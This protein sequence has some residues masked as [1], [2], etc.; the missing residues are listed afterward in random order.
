MVAMVQDG[1]EIRFARSGSDLAV[2]FVELHEL[3]ERPATPGALN[4]VLVQLLP[5]GSTR[6][7]RFLDLWVRAEVSTCADLLFLYQLQPGEATELYYLPQDG[8]GIGRIV[9]ARTA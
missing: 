1:R 6:E 8:Q 3:M 9:L 5:V 2:V 7:V 4:L